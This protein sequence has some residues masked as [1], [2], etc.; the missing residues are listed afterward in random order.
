MVRS[1]M[2]V[3][4]IVIKGILYRILSSRKLFR[5]TDLVIL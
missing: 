3:Q 5:L 4:I 2:I 1:L